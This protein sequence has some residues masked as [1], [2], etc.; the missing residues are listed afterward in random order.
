MELRQLRQ[1]AAVADHLH[2][3]RAA[4]ALSM[5]QPPLSRAIRS[6]E[7]EL[8]VALF[9]RDKKRVALADAGAALLPE[10]KALLAG[11]ERLAR[12]ARSAAEGE[13]GELT[14]AFVSIVDYSFLPRLLR[15][16]AQAWPGIRLV[17]REATT[18]VQ[19]QA[20]ARAE[21]DVGILLGPLTE[22]GGA[23]PAAHWL[24]YR[25]VQTEALVLALP[26]SHPRLKVKGLVA[27]R[28]FAQ[29]PFL[30]FPRHV[31]PRL[32]DA[33]IATCAEAGFSP[34]ISQEAIQM[35]T[36]ISLVSAGMG[37]ALVPASL[38][39][40]KRPGVVYRGLGGG[41]ASAV[42]IGMA[43]RRDNPSGALRR[44]VAQA[45]VGAASKA[46]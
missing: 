22:K 30:G 9:E 10:V 40:L 29:E 34:R 11:V 12:T 15:R 23:G 39:T 6:L 5:A 13:R 26:A 3:G 35:Q 14:L 43:W 24:E 44:F 32:H 41:K 17:L 18:D 25:R 7:Q 28:D 31:A 27:L 46:S 8:G 36:I 19:L 2:F 37:V 38:M 4:Q 45:Q 33:V 21:I 1:F 42:E 20:L 16:F